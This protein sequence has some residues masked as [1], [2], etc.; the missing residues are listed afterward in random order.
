MNRLRAV[1]ALTLLSMMAGGCVAAAIPVV[2]GGLMA[3][4]RI[5]GRDERKPEKPDGEQ[6]VPGQL[7]TAE[8][9]A[10]MGMVT[11]EAGSVPQ[12][13]MLPAPNGTVP[14]RLGQPLTAPAAS[15]PGTGEAA[16]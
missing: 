2:A 13:G 1:A 6:R 5:V 16:A 14:A 3:K 7:K 4:D 8:A 10:A 12:P 11:V 9:R 15:R